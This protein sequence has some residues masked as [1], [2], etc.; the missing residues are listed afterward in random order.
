MRKISIHKS[1]ISMC[2][3]M[4]CGLPARAALYRVLA[5]ARLYTRIVI[6]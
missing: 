5:E 6:V 4:R 2:K 1:I 3:Y